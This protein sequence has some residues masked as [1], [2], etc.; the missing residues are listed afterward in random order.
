MLALLYTTGSPFARAVRIVLDEIGLD[1][2][3][4]E[5]IVAP[6]AGQLA[7][8]TL[9]VPAFWDGDL[10]LW[11]SGTIVEYL[12]ST[13]PQRPAVEPPL[14]SQAFRADDLWR[15]K[16]VF[17]TIQTFGTAAT[18]VSQMMWTEVALDANAHL[19][20]SAEKLPHILGWLDGQLADPESGFQPGFLSVHDIFLAAHVRFV[21]ARPLG[22]DLFLQKYEKVASLLERLDERDSFKANP[23]WWWEPGIVGYT[24][25]GTPVFKGGDRSA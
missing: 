16:L 13:F 1:Y 22:I 19:K 2:E 14:A 17:S 11:E 20:R 18:T 8:P 9:Q 4:H 10:K 12:L 7:P 3:R 6:S 24:P 25:D 15:D 23:I 21:Q 5:R